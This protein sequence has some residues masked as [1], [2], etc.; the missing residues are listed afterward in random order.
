MANDRNNAE[1][2]VDDVVLVPAIIT[3]IIPGLG[4]EQTSVV[5]QLN[6]SCTSTEITMPDSLVVKSENQELD[7]AGVVMG[8]G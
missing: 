8:P 5:L 6:D 3:S 4:N 7:R 2:V 1:L